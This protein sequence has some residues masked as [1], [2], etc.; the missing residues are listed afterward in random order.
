MTFLLTVLPQVPAPPMSQTVCITRRCFDAARL[1][2][3]LSSLRT[4]AWENGSSMNLCPLAG[5][6][7]LPSVSGVCSDSRQ[8]AQGCICHGRKPAGFWSR[9]S[10]GC[11]PPPPSSVSPN[12]SPFKL[13]ETTV[14]VRTGQQGEKGGR[15]CICAAP[16]PPSGRTGPDFAVWLCVRRLSCPARCARC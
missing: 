11:V 16:A 7:Y 2:R 6:K 3:A 9:L 5:R 14:G 13:R 10:E 15:G 12:Q 4:T 1:S 8:G